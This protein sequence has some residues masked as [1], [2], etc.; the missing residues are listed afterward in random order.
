[1]EHDVICRAV[2]GPWASSF[3]YHHLHCFEEEYGD[4]EKL[5]PKPDESYR[6]LSSS[7]CS[8]KGTCMVCG[9]SLREA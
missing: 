3:Y 7:E 6:T 9:K 8:P 2:K 1:M 4:V 5:Q